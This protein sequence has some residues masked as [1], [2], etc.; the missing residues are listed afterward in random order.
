MESEAEKSADLDGNRVVDIAHIFHQVQNINH[1][2]FGCGFANLEF[3]KEQRN[4]FYSEFYFKC[5]MC[6]KNQRICSQKIKI[7]KILK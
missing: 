7:V 1:A 6:K 2:P 3:I 5:K 4:G